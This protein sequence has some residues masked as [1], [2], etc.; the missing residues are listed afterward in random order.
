MHGSNSKPY[1]ASSG[2][3]QGSTLGPTQFLIM[4]NDLPDLAKSVNC[5]MFAYDLK[6][7]L[8]IGSKVES[9]ALQCN[10]E[11]VVR[12]SKDNRLDFNI[13][14]CKIIT[15]TRSY[16][17]TLY[18]YSMEDV[19]VRV[20]AIHDLG[21]SLDTKLILNKHIEGLCSQALK[22]LGFLMHQSHNFQIKSTILILYYAYVRSKLKYNAIIGNPHETKYIVMLEKVQKR[23]LGTLT[24]ALCVLSAYG[25]GMVGLNTL[26]L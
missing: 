9:E 16:S 6:L 18:Q 22:S 15:F 14:N 26:E 5:L 23:L 25:A 13:A 8:S 17:P 1:L 12:W 24:M 10:I 21:L 20:K 19:L 7:N 2:V 4:I 3:S 11:S